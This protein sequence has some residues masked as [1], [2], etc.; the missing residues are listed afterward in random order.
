MRYTH[1]LESTHCNFNWAH[2]TPDAPTDAL[3]L[4]VS[5]SIQGGEHVDECVGCLCRRVSKY[6]AQ[7][8]LKHKSLGFDYQGVEM[9]QVRIRFAPAGH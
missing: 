9:V 4:S 6:L 7:N 5:P 1:R 3:S 8:G 2:V